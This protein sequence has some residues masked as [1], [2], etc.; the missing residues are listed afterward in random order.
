MSD[1]ADLADLVLESMVARDAGRLP[2]AR[3]YAATE[4][5]VAG[6][7]HMLSGWRIVSGINHVGHR[8]VDSE[9][10]QVFVT[11]NVDIGGSPSI[12]WGRL[13]AEDGQLTELELYFGRGRADGGFA[14]LPEELSA[15]QRGWDEP[16]PEGGRASRSELEDVARAVFDTRLEGPPPADYAILLEAGGVIFEDLDYISMIATGELAPPGASEMGMVTGMGLVPHRPHCDEARIVALDVDQ[17]IVVVAGRVDG[18]VSPY[19][20]PRANE[21]CFVPTPMIDNHHR[22]LRPE[23]LEGKNLIRETPASCISMQMVRVHSGL[24]HGLHLFN[25]ITAPGSR[26]PWVHSL[27][28]AGGVA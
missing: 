18:V 24:I 10:G 20:T 23:L 11:A 6:A 2:L 16:V 21:S 3:E 4:N 28:P 13:K 1:L 19:V 17:G 7:P 15:P 12:F 8:V 5:S 26:D 25:Q 14:L 9:L 27:T 22:T